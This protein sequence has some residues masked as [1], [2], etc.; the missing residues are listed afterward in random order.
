MQDPVT[1]DV[2]A[3]MSALGEACADLERQ[4]ARFGRAFSDALKGAVVEGRAFDDLLRQLGLRLSS[5]ALDAALKPVETGVT[6]LVERFASGLTGALAGSIG[7]GNA[8][9]TSSSIAAGPLPALR[10]GEAT[11]YAPGP[12]TLNVTT[13][14]AASFRR[15]E[16]QIAAMLARTASRGRRAL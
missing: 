13:P 11:S 12:I 6:G 2:D 3:D 10:R 15:S 7:G 4:A 16:G 1:I 8:T 5:I 14:D 9:A